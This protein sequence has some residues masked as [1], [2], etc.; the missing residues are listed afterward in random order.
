MKRAL[1]VLLFLSWLPVSGQF[2]ITLDR[3]YSD[4][5]YRH[6]NPSPDGSYF[7]SS[8]EK[9]VRVWNRIAGG[10]AAGEYLTHPMGTD[11]KTDEYIV[12]ISPDG[13]TII[14]ASD[15]NAQRTVYRRKATSFEAVFYFTAPRGDF[16]NMSFSPDGNLLVDG[17]MVWKTDGPEFTDKGKLCD[18]MHIHEESAFS[19]AMP[20]T[21]ISYTT[22]YAFENQHCSKVQRLEKP[23]T[24]STNPEF[25][26]DGKLLAIA[27]YGDVH[28]MKRLPDGTFKA[29]Q[30]NGD[31]YDPGT[32]GLV[33][34]SPD[35]KFLVVHKEKEKRNEDAAGRTPLKVFQVLR[36]TLKFFKDF[37]VLEGVVSD[38]RFIADGKFAVC[39]QDDKLTV[40]QVSGISAGKTT[41]AAS[42]AVNPVVSAGGAN[43]LSNNVNIFWITPNPDLSGDKPLVC[44]KGTVDIQ[45]KIISGKKIDDNDIR[46]I[47]NNKPLLQNKF[48]E[49][50]IKASTQDEL[51]EYTY[52]NVVPLEQT[53]NNINTVEVEAAGKRCPKKLKVLYSVSK[54]NLHIL[55]IG[56]ALDLQYPKKDAQ[57]FADLFKTQAGPG[58][59]KLFGSVNVRTLIGKDATTTAIKEAI[60]R[61]RYD[62]K[63]GAISPRDVM[64]VFISSHGFI[65]QD[66]FRIQGDDY[67][68]IYKETY[69]VAF[70]EITSR[71][72]EVQCKKLIFLDA[73]FSGG[74]KASVADINKAIRQL[75]AQGE[76]VTTFSSSSNEEYSYEDVKWQNGA[77]TFSIKEGLH[78]GKSDQD[79][80]GI[81]TIGELYDYVSGRVPKIVQDVKGQEQH[82]NMPLTNLLKNTTIY[83]VPKQ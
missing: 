62:F 21:F 52:T 70:D 48:N 51:F 17:S 47:V 68:D 76:G 34:F 58:D 67:K 36:D 31:V 60:E 69:S 37:D 32:V 8:G 16:K 41:P 24:I 35:G 83:V 45:L 19:P 26:P 59:D 82:P 10:F 7:I 44:E 61:F 50:K 72:N 9:G 27:S 63:T 53:S 49:V 22:L 1:H 13:N 71:L 40:L 29:L 2:G 5:K 12:C 39:L 81:I 30:E 79:G 15:N 3:T 14:V 25:S 6:V 66:K 43:P 80:N 11:G 73:C 20:V 54:P 64:L 38:F 46:V 57:D 55:S 23:G 77:F 56:T 42:P 33:R 65:Y 78:D 75:N 18:D 4:D 74:A 28:M